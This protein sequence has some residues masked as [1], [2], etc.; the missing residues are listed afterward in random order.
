MQILPRFAPTLVALV[1]AMA[2]SAATHAQAIYRC[3][4]GYSQ[5][6]CAEG[7]ALPAPPAPPALTDRAQAG[8]AAARDAR[9]ADQMEKERLREEARPASV[10]IPPPRE[11]APVQSRRSPEKSATPKLDVFTA[12]APGS[13]AKAA[14]KA[15]V[16]AKRRNVARPEADGGGPKPQ[17]GTLPA[18]ASR[19]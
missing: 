7:R 9:L 10:Y 13:T 16:K 6:P 11:Q 15:K 14:N 5:Q 18:P 1:A 8:Q 12:T 19:S 2:A 17:P 4:D 3:A